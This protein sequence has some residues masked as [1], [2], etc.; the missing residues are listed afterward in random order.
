M[1]KCIATAAFLLSAALAQAEVAIPATH[2]IQNENPGYCLWCSLEVLGRHQEIE[3]MA[4]LKD[5][6]KKEPAVYVREGNFTRMIN[7]AGG[8]PD[9][10]SR[11]LTKLNVKHKMQMPGNKDTSI[12]KEALTDGRG[13]AVGFVLSYGMHAVTL[14]DLDSK[15]AKFIDP[16]KVGQ[17]QVIDRAN[18][19]RIWDG[20]AITIEKKK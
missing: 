1:K 12:L 16:D 11:K 3:A 14:V 6:V 20:F 10:A 13:A 4:G 17:V 5:A 7:P 18:F 15:T 2:H 8:F 9:N 19:D